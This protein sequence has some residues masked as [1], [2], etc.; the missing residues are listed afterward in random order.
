MLPEVWVKIASIAK[1]YAAKCVRKLDMQV[2]ELYLKC[3]I[4]ML[5][6]RIDIRTVVTCNSI[7]FPPFSKCKN[8]QSFIFQSSCI[9]TQTLIHARITA[10]S[11]LSSHGSHWNSFYCD[12]GNKSCKILHLAGNCQECGSQK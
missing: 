6:I 12:A 7:T 11:K 2:Y 9:L 4:N 1:Y 8:I 3:G 10:A 5:D